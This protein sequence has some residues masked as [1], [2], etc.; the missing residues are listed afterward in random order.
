MIEKSQQWLDC[1]CTLN[2]EE[3]TQEKIEE[4]QKHIINISYPTN[5]IHAM[6]VTWMKANNIQFLC[7]PFEAEW[8]LVSLQRRGEI[9]VI[10][11]EDSDILAYGCTSIIRCMNMFGYCE[12]M[13]DKS[14]SDL[15]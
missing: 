15:Q 5:K 11:S 12:I 3:I 8:Q 9:D 13:D 10:I 4:S 1:Y 7:A 14:I 6:V 2:K